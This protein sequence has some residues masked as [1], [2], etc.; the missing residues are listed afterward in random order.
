MNVPSNNEIEAATLV[1]RAEKRI[2]SFSLFGL[3]G[4]TQVKCEEASEMCAKAGNLY[5]IEKKCM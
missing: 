1:E 4:S 5:K 3:G 2:N